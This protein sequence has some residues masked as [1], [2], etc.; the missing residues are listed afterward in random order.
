LRTKED[1]NYIRHQVQPSP[2]LS[3]TKYIRFQLHKLK[4]EK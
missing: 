2:R 1:N 4:E 3:V